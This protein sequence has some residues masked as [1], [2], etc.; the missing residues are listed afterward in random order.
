MGRFFSFFAPLEGE[1]LA[2]S[3][4][5]LA[6][7][8]AAAQV[9]SRLLEHRL[10]YQHPIAPAPVLPSVLVPRANLVASLSTCTDCQLSRCFSRLLD[11]AS[12]P[13]RLSHLFPN[14]WNTGI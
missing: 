4:E 3:A 13:N 7:A 11:A 1:N 8:M 10:R 9:E 14:I 2:A 5:G 6:E 12:T